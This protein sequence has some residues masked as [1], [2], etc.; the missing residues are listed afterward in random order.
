M[1]EDFFRRSWRIWSIES[2]EEVARSRSS[3]CTSGETRTVFLTVASG[4]EEAA[5]AAE[6]RVEVT[7]ESAVL[8]RRSLLTLKVVIIS[9]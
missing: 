3:W 4:E 8:S 9:C 2:P 5:A 1:F 7:V 6:A